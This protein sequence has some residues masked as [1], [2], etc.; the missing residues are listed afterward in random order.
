MNNAKKLN[1]LRGLTC[2]YSLEAYLTVFHRRFWC[3]VK[4]TKMFPNNVHH[5]FVGEI[6]E[7]ENSCLKPNFFSYG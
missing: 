3:M 2:S 1:P 7:Q 5:Y 6:K 4:E